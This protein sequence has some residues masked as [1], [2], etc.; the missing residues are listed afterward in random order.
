MSTNYELKQLQE[1]RCYDP[2]NVLGRQETPAG[3]VLRAFLPHAQSVE[4][5]GYGDMTR[6]EGSDVFETLLNEQKPLPQHYELIWKEKG[7]GAKHRTVSPYSFGPQAGDLDLHLFAQGKHRHAYRFLGAHLKEVDGYE[8]Y[9]FAVWVPAA[10]RVSVIGDFNA[11]DGRRHPMRCRGES[12][13]WELFIP[14][15]Q[16]GDSYKFEILTAAGEVI[17]KTDPYARAMALRPDTTSTLLGPD[18]FAWQDQK[19][20]KSRLECDWIHA[21]LSIYECHV[22]SWQRTGDNG[23][24]NWREIAARLIPYVWEMGF[25]HIELMPVAEHPLDESWGYQVSGYFS[26][27]SRF[28]SADDFRYFIDQCHRN[29]LGVILVTG[30]GSIESD[31]TPLPTPIS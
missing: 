11:W 1:G 9:Q 23:F 29:G 4:V 8:G 13:I 18:Q 16:Q 17:H 3:V 24:L 27:T 22:G 2:F 26:P 31:T 7:G 21:P 15:L 14:G 5:A 20:M 12:G 30:F 19:W 25:T 28:G 6:L 10:K